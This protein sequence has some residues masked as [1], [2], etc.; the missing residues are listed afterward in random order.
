MEPYSRNW[1]LRL[2][3]INFRLRALGRE[4]VILACPA[5][6][7]M[8]DRKALV[9]GI[10]VPW[11]VLKFGGGSVSTPEN[12]RTIAD[13]VSERVAEGFR[14]LIVQSAPAGVTLQLERLI[15]AAGMGD[16]DLSVESIAQAHA[17]LLDARGVHQPDLL[18]R[19]VDELTTLLESIS[20][21]REASPANKAR[22]L[23]IGEY[24]AT[25]VGAAL[26]AASGVEAVWVD[27]RDLLV[28]G[29]S[30]RGD[31]GH[32]LSAECGA[33]PD[34][35]LDRKLA[36]L[37]D[38]IITQGFVAR[39]EEGGTVVLGKGGSDTSAAYLAGRLDAERVEIWTDVPG[40]F[41]ADPRTV[42]AARLLRHLDH[43]EA[44]EIATTGASV[45]HP[46][47]IPALR[48][49]GIPIHI[50]STLFPDHPGTIISR[51]PDGGVPQ[52]KAISVRR[53][54]CL[55]SM[56]T[57]G[58]WQQV[59]FLADVFD[60]FRRRGISVDMVSTSETNVTV[61]LDA[62]AIDL[63][64]DSLSALLEDLG[65][66]CRARLIPSCAAISLVGR[67]VRALLHR[68][69]PVFEAFEEH[70]V[71]MVS[72]AASDLNLTFVV[73]EDRADKLTRDLHALLV[74]EASDPEVFG[75]TWEELAPAEPEPRPHA[76][77]I[78]QAP[79]LEEIARR[80][81]SAFVY[82]LETI[83]DRARRVRAIRGIDQV[84]YAMKANSH[85]GILAVIEEEGLGFECVSLPEVHA[86][87]DRFPD[88]ERKRVLFTPNFAPKEEYLAALELDVWLTLDSLYPLRHW[89]EL[90][91]GRDL[92]VRL[93][94]GVGKGHH[95]NVRTAGGH[96]KFGVP[97]FELEELGEL[98]D[99]VGA[100]IV[101]LHAHSG[102]GV[103]PADHWVEVG[104][105]LGAAASRLPHVRIVDLGG[106][107]AVPS[108]PGESDVDLTRLGEGLEGLRKK[109]PRL[110][111]WL[112]PGRY[113]VAEA[114]VLVSLVTQ[115]KGK[116]RHR[117]VGISTGMNSLIRPALY[118]AH[119]EIT[120]LSR[121]HAHPEEVVTVV[122]PICESGDRLGVDRLL[123][124]TS[125]GD[126]LLI[127]NAGA[128]GRV[129]S[130][131]YN[132][133]SPAIEVV[134]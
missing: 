108:R 48:D 31:R 49:R 103:S 25:R 58:M 24:M 76:W 66:Y 33:E 35:V 20:M 38:V 104:E 59:G 29:P 51:W 57:L 50:R 90:F 91:A 42:R 89:P 92:L 125:E 95:R 109:H 39:D 3:G 72:Q 45:I 81:R 102:S 111:I 80:H 127:A 9:S 12:W 15:E 37:G 53:G 11:I 74:S 41:T 54:V 122:G 121:L 26:L 32:Y 106:G 46:R 79:R 34:P 64:S 43:G 2:V 5:I 61:S 126:V 78:D 63:D 132:L 82:D 69:S 88:I 120:N 70:P 28:S 118:G 123:P 112:E 110:E 65:A 77:W 17:E 60:C 22:A 47:C 93:D 86:V 56:E 128:Y 13:V 85:E 71:H 115:T 100:R 87:L 1:T 19:D 131:S 116:G 27:A 133:R 7:A 99:A 107:L 8:A 21:A 83:R 134:L 96:S 30:T 40:M 4:A 44:Q 18:A 52:L 84:F 94:P 97:L 98:S 105:I 75:P 119:H 6:P 129:M 114:G 62:D 55:V 14:P 113:L 16:G 68:L 130:S 10:R 23:A 101:G 36:S 73:D 124:R 117:Y 67:G